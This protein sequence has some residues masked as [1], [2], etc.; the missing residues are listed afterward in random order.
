M[1]I[2]ITG[3]TGFVGGEIL[4]FLS[5]KFG[6]SNVHGTGR[7]YLKSKKLIEEGFN[8][9]VGDLENINFVNN[10]LR[11]YDL[12][13]HCAAKSSIWGTYNSFYR[14]NILATKNILNVLTDH[15]QIIYISSA[16]IYFN[17]KNQL[18]IKE[19]NVNTKNFSNFYS[20]TK[21]EAE[22]LVL[23]QSKDK[24][25]T[26]LRPRAIIGKNDTV[27]FPRLIKAFKQKKLKIIGNGKNII[28]FTSIK[29]L[30]HAINLCIIKKEI[31]NKKI[32]N[33]TND[34]T[35]NL[36]DK[37]IMIL[38]KL[39]YDPKL[40][41]VPY[42]LAYSFAK[43]NEIITSKKSNEPT[44]MTYSIAVLY[45]SV[46]LDITKIKLE[47]GYSPVESTQETFENFLKIFFLKN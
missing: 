15:S 26:V 45:F 38:T 34:E 44:L 43:L 40:K 18:N 7:N 20:K 17:Y 28:D 2:L 5:L 46:S 21:Y 13:I 16:N 22:K 47:L 41:S 1:K 9:L 10:Y 36:W 11:G 37:I 4:R 30:C 35:V 42:F 6:K 25:V 27:V 32:Y 8:I 31:A 39:G 23:N 19:E 33:I 3:V 29:N 14:A 24:Y 12:I